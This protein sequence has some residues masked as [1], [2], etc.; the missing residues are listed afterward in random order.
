MSGLVEIMDGMAAKITAAL[1]GAP[2]PI[3]V[4]G[5]MIVNPTPPSIDIF[6]GDPSR[7]NDLTG[8]GDVMGELIFTVRARVTT[9]DNEAGQDLMLAFMDDEHD[10]C[11]A[12]ALE[13]DQTLNGLAASVDAS[14]MS[15]MI[16]FLDPGGEGS[17]L[18]CQWT[19]LVVNAPS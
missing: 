3:Q 11:I 1:A 6:P 8:F 19:V 18:G 9:A 5:R 10:Y 16:P 15:G 7:G 13:A 4:R 14:D 17:L 12:A 2:W